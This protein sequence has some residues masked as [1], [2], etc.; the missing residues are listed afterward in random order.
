MK[1]PTEDDF[2]VVK[3]FGSSVTALFEPT[4]GFYTFHRL[5]DPND[6]KRLGP[7]HRG[8]TIFAMRAPLRHR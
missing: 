7:C 4:Q 2:T 5:V 1:H 8:R 6:V 3:V